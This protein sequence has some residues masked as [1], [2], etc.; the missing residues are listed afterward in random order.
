L[1]E[2]EGSEPG[3]TSSSGLA[4]L[5]SVII[6]DLI[7]FG[8]VVPI[9]PFW[10]ERFGAN[11]VT[12]GLL[13]ASHAAMQFLFAP[14]WGRLS[15]RIGRRPVMLVTIAGTALSLLF[16]GLADSLVGLFLARLL[17]G[18]FGSNISV[19]TAYVTDVTDEADRTRWM[20]M[21]GA[22]FAVGFTLGPPIGGVLSRIGHEV[23]MLVAAAMAFVN[24]IWAAISLR[25]PERHEARPQ[26]DL[27]S[28][29]D[30]L[31][32]PLIGRICGIYFL[33]S[34]AVTQLE[35]TFAF[36]MSH[37]FG[38]DELG[39]GLVMLGMAVVMGGIQGGGMK[40]LSA[41]FESRQLVL[42]GLTLMAL[43]FIAVPWPTSVPFLMLPLGAAAI[44]RGISQPPML[45]LVSLATDEG[46]R[47]LVMGVFQSTAS[48]ARIVGPV[49]AGFLYDLGPE[50][51]YW[52]AAGLTALAAALALSLQSPSS[53]AP[54]AAAAAKT[55]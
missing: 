28:R 11:G 48:A 40:R 5:F 14:A 6:V 52:M 20:G 35:T 30:V 15:D 10:S 12:L 55:S 13:L 43:A 37:R 21:I 34:L 24:L 4:V 32:A 3:G 50:F 8:I 17:S 29:L 22:S 23:P 39:V 7:G 44:G 42:T 51:P 49:M 2:I 19:A 26:A 41:R 54:R 45:S 36:F 53:A 9:L 25:E 38:Y 1:S 46:S 33:F 16:L 47:G 31:R 18:L 27:T